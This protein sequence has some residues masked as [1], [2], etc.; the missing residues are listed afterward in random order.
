MQLF[1]R[2]SAGVPLSE[3]GFIM[4]VK[5]GREMTMV[6]K[7]TSREYAICNIHPKEDHMPAVPKP[8]KRVAA[9]KQKYVRASKRAP[10]LVQV[11]ETGPPAVRTVKIP[12]HGTM[13]AILQAIR[14]CGGMTL[15]EIE[16]ECRLHP[17]GKHGVRDAVYYAKKLTLFKV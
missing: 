7:E 11:G 6:S 4:C 9:P 16:V 3:R 12:Q 10:D 15:A 8:S 13:G 14:V 2:N 1:A 5:C 17:V